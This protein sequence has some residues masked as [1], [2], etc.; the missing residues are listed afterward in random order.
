MPWTMGA[1]AVASLSMIGLP[2]TVGFISK[3]YL[4]GGAF[5]AGQ[6]AAVGVLVISTALNAA[7]FLPIVYSAFMKP[8]TH[9]SDHPHGEAPLTMVVSLVFTAAVTVGLFFW[10]ELPLS[11][12]QALLERGLPAGS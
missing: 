3:W 1:F 2:P 4:L 12:A 11:L 5:E 7:Y 10:P 6:W 9:S 8:E